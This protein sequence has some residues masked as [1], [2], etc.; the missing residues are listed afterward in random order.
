MKRLILPDR[1]KNGNASI[2]SIALHLVDVPFRETMQN[3]FFDL[4]FKLAEDINGN[5]VLNKWFDM[6]ELVKKADEFAE[7]HFVKHNVKRKYTGEP[8][9]VH[10]REVMEIVSTV[11]H[12]E[13]MLAAAL[14]HDTVEDTPV[15]IEEIRDNFGED[16]AS[17]V[18]W[19][20]DV[21]KLSDGNR[22]VRKAIDR[23]H[24]GNAPARAQTI[25]LA[26]LISN[27]KSIVHY[28]KNFAVVYL[29]EKRKL[30]EV[31]KKGDRTLWNQAD[32]MVKDGLKE[33]RG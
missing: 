16:I 24:S 14:L 18:G 17:L 8:Y 13:Q 29:R 11:H 32:K 5:V 30:L 1:L 4:K 9:M 22:K 2:Y 23:E 27:T 19:L 25:K 15:T 12:D 7:H 28:D 10:P 20:T 3:T 26:D 33:L 21:S 6:N 31:M